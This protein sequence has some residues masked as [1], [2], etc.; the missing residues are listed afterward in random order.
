[1]PEPL[2]T[3]PSKA[4]IGLGPQGCCLWGKASGSNVLSLALAQACGLL[5]QLPHLV[6]LQTTLGFQ[7]ADGLAL[8]FTEADWDQQTSVPLQ[9]HNC[10]P[11]R[12]EVCSLVLG[13]LT[14]RLYSCSWSG[15]AV[16]PVVGTLVVRW[17]AESPVSGMEHCCGLQLALIFPPVRSC[18]L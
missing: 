1:M 5:W 18:C 2:S 15:A 3:W 4:S 11:G 14:S 9:A 7:Q 10:L 13:R 6:S 16:Q 12:G 17:P 8:V